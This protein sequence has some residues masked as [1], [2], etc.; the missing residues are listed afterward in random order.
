MAGAERVRLVK[1][2]AR[3]RKRWV[4]IIATDLT[5]GAWLDPER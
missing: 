1:V 2:A 3:R 4:E 5:H